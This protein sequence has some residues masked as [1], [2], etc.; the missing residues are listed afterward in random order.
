MPEG[1]ESPL[2]I[3][4]E[5]PFTAIEFGVVTP[6]PEILALQEGLQEALWRLIDQLPPPLAAG[7][8]TILQGYG[9]DANFVR[10][11][12]QPIWSFLHWVPLHA[13][14]PPRPDLLAAAKE[15]HTLSLFLHLW[16][17]HLS[18]GQLAPDLLRLHLRTLAW[19]R[20]TDRCG[21]LCAGVGADPALIDAHVADYLT[22]LHRPASAADLGAYDARFCRQIAIWRLV[23]RLLGL[24]VGGEAVAGALCR[25]IEALAEAWRWL[26]DI[27]D[28]DD[29][30]A[31]G[32][33]TAVWLTLDEEGRRRWAACRPEPLRSPHW[34][35]LVR[36]IIESGCLNWLRQ[37]VGAKLSEAVGIAED[38]GWPEL[39]AEL[40]QM[41][42][43]FVTA[44]PGPE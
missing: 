39:A 37:Q 19:Q 4:A 35:A 17:D 26:D 29:D 32:K 7:A 12:Y 10:L 31:E 34:G 11:F 24:T 18:D 14:T 2:R 21:A 43:P 44:S 22:S 28:I 30:I 27:Q 1:F 38:Q 23:P 40:A 13:A 20:F 5:T 41:R 9:G 6:T 16:D 36:Y 15:A 33:E 8:K 3:A 42:Q 25:L